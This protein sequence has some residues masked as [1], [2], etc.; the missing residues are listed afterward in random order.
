MEASAVELD[1]SQVAS[2]V[3]GPGTRRIVFGAPGTGKTTAVVELVARHLADGGDITRVLVLTSSRTTAADLR[4][5]LA[6]RT[7]RTTQGPLARSVA[8]LAHALVTRD[9]MARHRRPPVL[10]S[11]GD[12]DAA[13]RRFL[14]A[15]AA[16][17][18]G[19]AWPEHLDGGVRALPEFRAELREFIARLVERGESAASFADRAR[20]S[21]HAMLWGAVAEAWRRFDDDLAKGSDDVPVV[22]LST[23]V[24]AARELVSSRLEPEYDLVVVD[25]AQELTA[26][27]LSLVLALAGREQP[28][29]PRQRSRTAI[30]LFAATDTT[31]GVFRGAQPGQLSGEPVQYFERSALTQ[32]HRFGTAIAD[33]YRRAVGHV[34]VAGAS[35]ERVF[36]V[37]SERG[38]AADVWLAD[39]G[40]QSRLVA[41]VLRRRHLVDGVPWS[42]M[43]VIVRTSG[44]AQ[45]VADDLAALEVP[46]SRAGALQWRH[47][48]AVRPL[49]TL[50]A[51][52]SGAHELV[53]ADVHEL[54]SS[55]Y[56]DIDALGWRRLRRALRAALAHLEADE[57]IDETL[58]TAL[59]S[60]EHRD[61][62]RT[63]LA[64]TPLAAAVV[65]SI[66]RLGHA[67]DEVGR[68]VAGP[69]GPALWAGWQALEVAEPW[70][71]AATGSGRDAE[72]ANAH[73]DAVLGL[74]R[75]SD[76][77]SER[78]PDLS[79]RSFVTDWLDGSV[80]DDSI[81]ATASVET[82]R[83]G[84][85]ASFVSQEFDTVVVAGVSDGVWPNL[86]LR[87]SLLRA[88]E[89]VRGATDRAE[90][91]HDEA[92][93]FALAVSRA[94]SRLAVVTEQ[95]EH[96]RP[97]RFVIGLEPESAP[98]RLP[99]SLRT[100][101][102]GQRRILTSGTSDEAD[103]ATAAA[104]LRYLEQ[105]GV[106]GAGP[107]DWHGMLEP[108]TSAP[109]RGPGEQPRISPSKIEQF[110]DC[111]VAWA[112]S[113]LAGESVGNARTIGT[114]VHDAVEHA[115]TFTAGELLDHVDATWPSL[116]FETPWEGE[117]EHAAI[118]HIVERLDAYFTELGAAGYRVD[119][120]LREAK[121]RV[122]LDGAVL[123]GSIDW[124]ERG[125]DGV[126]ICDLKTGR[127]QVTKDEA[128]S[129]PQ[130]LAYQLAVA[131]GGV[132]GIEPGTPVLGA[133][134]VYP[135]TDAVRVSSMVR[136][137]APRSSAQ[138][139]EFAAAVSAAA[140]RM[141]GASFRTVPE[142]HC[143]KSGGAFIPECRIHVTKQVTE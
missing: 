14:E 83:V 11:G 71:E 41:D 23:V 80:D 18:D 43:A 140:E 97:S 89:F 143:L 99:M 93:L 139:A 34:G 15:D 86:R 58:L 85:P 110:D 141:A 84:T 114:L 52:A 118:E 108:S 88:D 27:A 70:Y 129:H 45:Q 22:T 116:Q 87:S 9:S 75:Q 104:V 32:Q 4:D 21:A 103:R 49:T 72:V 91:L 132:D 133:R 19:I 115:T 3:I 126:R 66:E 95:S 53:T 46:V 130:L 78:F 131:R 142:S 119:P 25:D 47:S 111:E 42:E 48:A 102:A 6:A 33:V 105:H 79:V 24:R 65:E 59:R 67:L 128:Q 107:N 136:E 61:Q 125:P 5:R 106:T 90:V 57:S 68:H 30:V 138:L 60:K 16:S 100:L 39:D 64:G 8:S 69:P 117:S 124:V 135:R 51:A 44:S 2:T 20:E 17:A 137:Q 82:V 98:A 7:G 1:P 28:A 36:D 73:L 76:V 113:T 94:R 40:D 101:I 62:L 109:L 134:L 50:L 122:E 26:G 77:F 121:L 123:T 63:M 10:L 35:P 96:D 38:G 31:A 12:E 112:A 54:L 37:S 55:P 29:D 13:W 56:F 127:N 81:A 92:R 120:R 74:F